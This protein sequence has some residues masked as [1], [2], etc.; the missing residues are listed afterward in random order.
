MT[1]KLTRTGLLFKHKLIYPDTRNP[2]MP[3][4]V[5]KPKPYPKRSIRISFRQENEL[6]IVLRGTVSTKVSPLPVAGWP[7]VNIT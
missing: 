3:Y 6:N 4:L 7:S 2:A 5:S 1:D